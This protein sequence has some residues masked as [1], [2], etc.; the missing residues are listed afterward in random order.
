MARLTSTSLPE[1]VCLGVFNNSLTTCSESKVMKQKPL[2]WFFCLSNGISISAI[3]WGRITH[4]VSSGH[5]GPCVTTHRSKLAEESLD[6]VIADLGRQAT[7][8]DLALARLGLLGIDLLVVDYMVACGGHLFD[9]LRRAED[10]ECKATGA[11][12]LW[13]CLNVNTID[14]SVLA[15]V[16]PELLCGR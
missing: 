7:H 13:V 1:M 3:W 4:L 6:L 2:R 15:K 5:K 10:N 14:V 8:K 11:A 12:S 9:G 16:F